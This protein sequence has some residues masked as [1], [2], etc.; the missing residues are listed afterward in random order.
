M[1]PKS[2]CASADRRNWWWSCMCPSLSVRR[3]A[4]WVYH[5][6]CT[7]SVY[8]Q[9]D[10]FVL[11]VG[12]NADL[13]ASSIFCCLHCSKA[14]WWILFGVFLTRFFLTFNKTG[15]ILELMG[16]RMGKMLWPWHRLLPDPHP[17]RLR[18]S[19]A[20][21]SQNKREE[22]ERATERVGKK[23]VFIYNEHILGVHWNS[24]SFSNMWFLLPS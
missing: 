13:C 5:R 19:S 3:G 23:Y 16:K 4:S 14:L 22:T 11:G 20:G 24:F 21:W 9:Y 15:S 8:V 17:E 10:V 7:V 18:H 6:L 12:R 2:C 1:H